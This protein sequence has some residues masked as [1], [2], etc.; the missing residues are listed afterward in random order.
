ME[1][2]AT[3]NPDNDH[4]YNLGGVDTLSL[5]AEPVSVTDQ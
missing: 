2:P 3:V 5:G 4:I 1:I